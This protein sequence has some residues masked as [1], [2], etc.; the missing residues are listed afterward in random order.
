MS[1]TVCN[2]YNIVEQGF[3]KYYTSYK[4]MLKLGS[5]K[6]VLCVLNSVRGN[7]LLFSS[8]HNA[9]AILQI[10]KTM[11]L[12]KFASSSDLSFYVC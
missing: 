5:L 4:R 10:P 12:L 7:E 8:L 3:K 2:V 1:L 6:I 9:S 11:F